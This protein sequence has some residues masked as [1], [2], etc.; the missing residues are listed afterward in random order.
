MIFDQTKIMGIV[1]ATP[2]SYIKG[3][4]IES[5]TDLLKKVEKMLN[6]GADIID[7]GGY[8]TR[9]GAQ[10]VDIQTECQ[11]IDTYSS[12]I[13]K[14]FPTA[15]L[16]LDTFRSEVAKR[17]LNNGVDMI[18]DVSAGEMD[19]EL[20]NLVAEFGVPYII[21]HMRGTPQTMMEDTKYENVCLEVMSNLSEKI[22]RF[23]KM[24]IIDII[25]D[26]GIG[27]SKT[28]DQNF[29]VLRNIELFKEL[30]VPLLL[31][32]SKKSLLRSTF[33]IQPEQ[34]L[35]ITSSLHTYLI[36]KGINILR[37]HDVKEAKQC[38]EL[39]NLLTK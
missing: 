4:R 31:G 13:K 20:P 19:S 16:S 2:D 3:S 22:R 26:P 14:T 25:A 30:N 11:R 10:D 7:L 36:N 34:A 18:N 32:V 24:G 6:D 27:F 1:N 38:V 17:G 33:D 12:L 28:V 15:V 21:M 5:E 39:N 35:S 8:S 37:V 9:P 23:R 29:A